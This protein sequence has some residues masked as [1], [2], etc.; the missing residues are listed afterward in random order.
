VGRAAPT[1]TAPSRGRT[2]FPFVPVGSMPSACSSSAVL[3]IT[4]GRSRALDQGAEPG[5]K[6]V[7]ALLHWRTVAPVG[8]RYEIL[9]RELLVNRGVEVKSEGDGFMLAFRD[10][11]DALSLALLHWRIVMSAVRVAR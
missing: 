3:V 7:G 9:R 10:P 4:H 5:F 2:A 8:D 11:A 1:T 6:S